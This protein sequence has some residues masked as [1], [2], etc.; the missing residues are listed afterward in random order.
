[1]DKWLAVSNLQK[2]VR[3]GNSDVAVQ[4]ATELWT[5][6]NAYLRYRTS[7]I[8]IEDIGIA[9][10]DLLN[11]AFEGKLG[12][13]W[14]DARGGL[15]WF[16]DNVIAPAANS[17]KDRTS[18]DWGVVSKNNKSMFEEKFGSFESLTLGQASSIV[19]SKDYT[20]TE[21]G[22]AAWRFAGSD[23]FPHDSLPPVKGDWEAWLEL[24]KELG[25][26]ENILNVMRMSQKSQREW[27]SIYLGLSYLES[28]SGT[29]LKEENLNSPIH[30]GILLAACD[31]HT[32]V[33]KSAVSTFLTKNKELQDALRQYNPSIAYD[34][35][36]EA[37]GKLVFLLEGG[38]V[39]KYIS[40]AHA[41]KVDA[42][43]KQQ[44]QSY[45]KLP[46]NVLAN[47]VWKSMPLLNSC[48]SDIIDQLD[49][50]HK[51][52]YDSISP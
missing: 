33:G 3:R 52:Q 10:P 27:H 21:R 50:G 12:K 43:A 5:T 20:L 31:V 37:I 34:D 35:A 23:I 51:E 28:L 17:V 19:K 40:Y 14:I 4:T 22:L 25:V 26:P 45:Y 38:K 1:M 15:P 13:R 47:I 36:K 2:A 46:G 39:S 32:R 48:R 6:E 24:N 29:T 8:L 16:I 49:L 44:W 41:S 11:M 7:V 18:C 30:N 9:N 42:T